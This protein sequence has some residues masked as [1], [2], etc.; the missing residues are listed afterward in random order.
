MEDKA[1]KVLKKH[2]VFA[3]QLL[4]HLHGPSA[5]FV[6]YKKL[7][8]VLHISNFSHACIRYT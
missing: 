5:L 3:K 2:A 7:R 1:K 6:L 8:Q 4:G